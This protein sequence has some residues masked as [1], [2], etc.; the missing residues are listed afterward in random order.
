MSTILFKDCCDLFKGITPELEGITL[1][2]L[3]HYPQTLG[4]KT[5]V[6][7][8]QANL[9]HYNQ[10]A[11]LDP[12]SLVGR[13]F[14]KAY[15]SGASNSEV[16]ANVQK[17]ALRYL[18]RSLSHLSAEEC[19]RFK[20]DPDKILETTDFYPQTFN[21][22]GELIRTRKARNLVDF[23]LSHFSKLE[24]KL[25]VEEAQGDLEDL[26][27]ILDS[28]KSY[29]PMAAQLR[30]W[31]KRPLIQE[32]IAT[33]D[34]SFLNHSDEIV[35]SEILHLNTDIVNKSLYTQHDLAAFT[36]SHSYYEQQDMGFDGDELFKLMVPKFISLKDS[37]GV[38]RL[39][40]HSLDQLDVDADL[41]VDYHRSAFVK[42]KK[43]ISRLLLTH[44]NLAKKSDDHTATAIAIALALD[45]KE[46]FKG[47]MRPYTPIQRQ[48]LLSLAFSKAIALQ[49]PIKIV[50]KIREH[51]SLSSEDWDNGMLEAR[52]GFK[53]DPQKAAELC[54][55]LL[56][57]PLLD[58]SQPDCLKQLIEAFA[59]EFKY[60]ICHL[61]AD[62]LIRVLNRFNPPTDL[63]SRALD[64]VV[65]NTPAFIEQDNQ[66]IRIYGQFL[67][68]FS[69]S[70]LNDCSTRNSQGYRPAAFMTYL[71]DRRARV[72]HSIVQEDEKR[73]DS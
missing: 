14:V 22:M 58:N 4:D 32:I 34:W 13:F 63:R 53:H 67:D 50:Q 20:I 35:P 25:L 41:Y 54:D 60:P 36:T 19:H 5:N 28:G 30:S 26:R 56:A 17:G 72:G 46:Q 39:I 43:P 62:Y 27:G 10:L 12:K 40:Q 16:V 69:I 24:E 7:V 42:Q 3:T 38:L 9:C 8:K 68:Q 48:K 45:D 11:E 33:I 57:H 23:C 37:H 29:F 66:P 59:K 55:Y 2:Y 61:K 70:E 15:K 73:E 21:A 52:R 6:A 51:T 65:Q 31:F 47:L 1:S 49:V 64:W 18:N 44:P 71:T